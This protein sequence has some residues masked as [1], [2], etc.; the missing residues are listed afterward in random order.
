MCGGAIWAA[1]ACEVGIQTISPMT[2]TTITAAITATWLEASNARNG[3]PISRVAVAS[4]GAGAMRLLA[5]V[6][7]SWERTTRAGLIITSRPQVEGD[8]A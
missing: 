7:R 5:R 3:R 6:S 4:R 1:I 2:K 8:R